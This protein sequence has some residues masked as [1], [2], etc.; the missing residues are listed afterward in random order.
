[1][2]TR[3]EYLFGGRT[4]HFHVGR[5]WHHRHTPDAV[6]AQIRHRIDAQFHFPEDHAR[7]SG[8]IKVGSQK[9]VK[10]P[11]FC[12][13]SFDP[14]A[15][16]LPGI[17]RQPQTASRHGVKRAQIHIEAQGK[18]GSQRTQHDLPLIFPAAQGRNADAFL[19]KRMQ[20]FMDRTQVNGMGADFHECIATILE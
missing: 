5:T 1:M 8:G 7:S 2:R 14:A 17:G 20:P 19:T 6:V 10:I 3:T 15:L 16:P 18:E 9:G 4:G 12:S 13:F 11:L